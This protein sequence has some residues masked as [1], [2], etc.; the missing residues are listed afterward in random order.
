MNTPKVPGRLLAWTAL[1]VA[2]AAS[3]AANVAFAMPALGP[4]LSSGVAPV[5][6]VLAAGLLERVPLSG[7]RWWR[8]TLAYGGLGVVVV[9]AFVTS[10]E[11]QYRLLV[12]YGNPALS[13][14]LLPIAVDGLIV[15]ASVCLTVIAERRRELA[16]LPVEVLA[17]SEPAP[18]VIE[19][20]PA[21]SGPASVPLTAHVPAVVLAEVR[22]E[23]TASTAAPS[24][25]EHVTESEQVSEQMVSAPRQ[26]RAR[27]HT[28]TVADKVARYAQR[29]PDA[30][31]AVIAVKVGCTERTVR[32]HLAALTD[33]RSAPAASAAQPD[34]ERVNGTEVPSLVEV[35][36]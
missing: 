18:A 2:L 31:P 15:L 7:V 20:A 26:P 28:P 14:V 29:H 22:R 21:A 9:A 25:P 34:L 30:T 16:A 5:L 36:G 33:A 13:A 12:Q 17:L 32:R 10:F 35:S 6:V 4:R 8:R 27:R 19:Q 23:L 11:H 24:A 1:L 3:V